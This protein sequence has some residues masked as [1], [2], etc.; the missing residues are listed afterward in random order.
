MSIHENIRRQNVD[1][2]MHAKHHKP[3]SA[4]S[5]PFPIFSH[6]FFRR[7]TVVLF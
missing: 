3:F 1:T 2:R 7:E 5:L 6:S 4:F